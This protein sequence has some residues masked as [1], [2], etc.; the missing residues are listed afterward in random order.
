MD[1]KEK[2]LTLAKCTE[3]EQGELLYAY[4]LDLLPEEDMKKFEV[5]LFDCEYCY[6]QL[7]GFEREADLLMSNREFKVMAEEAAAGRLPAAEPLVKRLRRY[8]WPE[9]PLLLK[10]ALTYL[11]I[12]FLIFPAYHGLRKLSESKIRPVQTIQLFFDRSSGE[13]VFKISRNSDGLISFVFEVAVTGKK[14]YVYITSDEGDTIF[15]QAS[16]HNFDSYGTG[17][18]LLP[19]D[20][21]K[22]GGYRLILVDPQAPPPS[23]TWQYNFEIKQ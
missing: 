8:L 14:Y 4:E 15:R 6:T 5:H 1:E 21:M 11:L 10:P 22:P 13:D 23:N 7:E 3:P 9:A 17:R 12:L 20:K 19:H 18:L 16:F 2:I